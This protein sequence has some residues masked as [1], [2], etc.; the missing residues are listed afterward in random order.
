[1]KNIIDQ[2]IKMRSLK[3]AFYILFLLGFSGMAFAQNK[4]STDQLFENM[5]YKELIKIYEAK[6]KLNAQEME[7]IANGYRLNHDPENAALWFGEVVKKECHPSN[8]LY[9]AQAL[10]SVG[11]PEKAKVYFLKYDE[12][13]GS[14]SD[15]QRG[16]TLAAAIDKVND[17]E[18][19]E[20]VTL[21]REDAINSENLDFS[22]ALYQDGIVFVSSRKLDNNKKYKWTD[23]YFMNLYYASPNMEGELTNVQSFSKMIN[24]EYHEG[25][26]AFSKNFDRIFFT[27]N[28]HLKGKLNKNKKGVMKLGIFT[29]I[30]DGENWTAPKALSFNTV[31]YEECHPSLSA[32]GKFL[33]FASD[34]AGGLGGMDIY[35]SEFN[36]GA[37]SNPRNLGPTINTPGNDVFPFIHENGTLYFASDGWGGLGGL[38]IFHTQK[39]DSGIWAQATNIG[40][41]YNSRKDDFG[42]VLNAMGTDGYLNSSRDGGKGKDDIYSFKT[43]ASKEAKETRVTSTENID[44]SKTTIYQLINNNYT[45]ITVDKE[46]ALK[47][48]AEGQGK[49]GQSDE[50]IALIDGETPKPFNIETYETS[51]TIKANEAKKKTEIKK[52]KPLPAFDLMVRRKRLN[53]GESFELNNVYF[54]FNKSELDKKGEKE[55]DKLLELMKKYPE[56]KIELSAHTDSRGRDRYN[57]WL[58]RRRAESTMKYL[59]DRGVE[60][61]RIIA[62]GYG[63]SQ[64]RNKCTDGVECE[65]KYHQINRRTEV[66]ILKI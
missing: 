44:D 14:K 42:F 24:S 45:E 41:P 7:H 59:T 2:I 54:A 30:R 27:R 26:V 3:P 12:L 64:L 34:R 32:N 22:P 61:N 1:M 65:E 29:A 33:Y 21:K 4:V 13:S 5:A 39:N 52:E 20:D 38:D 23:E 9:Y 40:Q 48:L 66:K 19:H 31:E 25:P 47:M 58:S 8:Y 56:M 49:V 60:H 53:V 18:K 55:L 63:E 57:T 28:D 43:N 6:G 17:W 16:I 15:D 62:I 11:D 10:Q 51:E 37:W 46:T 50:G 36:A 35:V